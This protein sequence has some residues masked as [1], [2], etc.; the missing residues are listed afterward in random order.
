MVMKADR[1][2]LGLKEILIEK[3]REKERKYLDRI[4]RRNDEFDPV[5]Y[6]F[7]QVRSIF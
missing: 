1:W 5:K 6:R 3:R 7:V 4:R 2:G